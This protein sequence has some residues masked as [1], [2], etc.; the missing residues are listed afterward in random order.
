MAN[1]IKRSVCLEC[2]RFDGIK[3]RQWPDPHRHYD[4]SAD[5]ATKPW[6]NQILRSVQEGFVV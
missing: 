4:V 2:K 6:V 1:S 3:A 5:L